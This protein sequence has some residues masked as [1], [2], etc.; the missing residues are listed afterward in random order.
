MQPLGMPLTEWGKKDKHIVGFETNDLG[1]CSWKSTSSI[2]ILSVLISSETKGKA[3]FWLYYI[4]L[5]VSLNN[6]RKFPLEKYSILKTY[7][8][9]QREEIEEII[10]ILVTFIDVSTFS[11]FNA[12][13]NP[14]RK[15][16]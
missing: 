8:N 14:V 9:L 12:Q 3:T 15:W 7:Q 10:P 16:W 2:Q 5:Y 4:Y 11:H 6:Y 13:N 1:N